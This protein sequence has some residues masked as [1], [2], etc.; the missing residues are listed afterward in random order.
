MTTKQHV[1]K[2]HECV[3]EFKKETGESFAEMDK[4]NALL[5]QSLETLSEKVDDHHAEAK[6]SRKNV[7]DKLGE[8]TAAVQANKAVDEERDRKAQAKPS[9]KPVVGRNQW[10]FFVEVIKNPALTWPLIFALGLLA[11]YAEDIRKLMS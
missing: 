2:L 5:K 3:D 1:A 10:D 6:A 11:I 9:S 8:L 4:A 7:Y